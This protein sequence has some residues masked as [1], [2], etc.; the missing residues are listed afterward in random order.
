MVYFVGYGLLFLPVDDLFDFEVV[1]MPT[2]VISQ[3]PS[4]TLCHFTFAAATAH[5]LLGSDLNIE[6]G[7]FQFLYGISHIDG[8]NGFG[9]M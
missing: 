8:K 6:D 9:M 7:F 2:E 4:E 1:L 3:R 5:Q